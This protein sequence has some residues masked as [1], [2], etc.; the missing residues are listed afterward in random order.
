VPDPLRRVRAPKDL[1]SATAIGEEAD[2]EAGGVSARNVAAIWRATTRTVP[3]AHEGRLDL[4]MRG[5]VSFRR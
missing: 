4:D 3:G 5:K 1:D 2:P